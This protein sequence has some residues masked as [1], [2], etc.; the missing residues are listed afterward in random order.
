[1]KLVLVV[2]LYSIFKRA[3]G[4]L[5]ELLNKE[6]DVDVLTRLKDTAVYLN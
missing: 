1:M 3:S 2:P 5:Q 4:L 6:V